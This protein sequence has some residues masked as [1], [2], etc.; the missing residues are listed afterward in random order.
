MVKPPLRRT[1]VVLLSVC[2]GLSLALPTSAGPER[3]KDRSVHQ[4]AG[5][6]ESFGDSWTRVLGG[7]S[8]LWQNLGATDDPDGATATGQGEGPTSDPELGPTDDPDG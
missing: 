8:A 2:L 5:F 4:P 1:A 3:A 6:L 7:L